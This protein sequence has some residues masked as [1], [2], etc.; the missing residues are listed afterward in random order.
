[1]AYCA[2][3][4]MHNLCK[5]TMWSYGVCHIVHI[6]GSKRLYFIHIVANLSK[7]YHKLHRCCRIRK[8][9]LSYFDTI[10]MH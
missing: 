6:P 1:M 4:Q 10:Q 3:V 5:F 7:V 2:P 9:F 8:R